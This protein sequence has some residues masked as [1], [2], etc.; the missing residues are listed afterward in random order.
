MEECPM[1]CPKIKEI[2]REK[3]IKA[4]HRDFPSLPRLYIE[5]M[6]DVLDKMPKEE[7]DEI[8]SKGLWEGPGKFTPAP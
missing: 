4:A 3:E 6:W 8:I 7:Q 5:W 1:E 2:R